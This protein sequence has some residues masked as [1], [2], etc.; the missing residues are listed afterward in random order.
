MFGTLQRLL[1]PLQRFNRIVT[2]ISSKRRTISSKNHNDFVET[3]HQFLRNVTT[4]TSKLSQRFLRNVTTIFRNVHN[5]FVE[6]NF[7]DT[8]ETPHPCILQS[9]RSNQNA[10]VRYDDCFAKLRVQRI[11]SAKSNYVI[12]GGRQAGRQARP[13]LLRVLQHSP[14]RSATRPEIF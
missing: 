13:S 4:I 5:I 11:A 6:K 2:T 9:L 10:V 14:E 1:Q 7:G 3:S 8:V 12:T